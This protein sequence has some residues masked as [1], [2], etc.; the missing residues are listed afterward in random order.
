MKRKNKKKNVNKKPEWN[1]LC[2]TLSTR[3]TAA[4]AAAATVGKAMCRVLKWNAEQM[5]SK[6]GTVNGE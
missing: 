4:A 3:A 1:E 6:Q 2:C 5:G